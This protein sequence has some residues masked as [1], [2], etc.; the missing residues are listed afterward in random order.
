MP[1]NMNKEYL[2]NKFSISIYEK[3]SYFDFHVFVFIIYIFFEY[4]FFY[5]LKYFSSV[6]YQIVNNEK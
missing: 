2:N 4:I 6:I 1:F 3:K 5:I